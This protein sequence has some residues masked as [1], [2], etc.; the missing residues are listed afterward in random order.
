[1]GPLAPFFPYRNNH[2]MIRLTKV[3]AFFLLLAQLA[4]FSSISAQESSPAGGKNEPR[5][6]FPETTF[7]FGRVKSST[8][9]SHQFTVTNTGKARLEISDVRP[10]CGCT[11]PGKW[12]RQIEPGQSGKIPIQFNPSGFNGSVTKTITV[13]SN[14][15]TQPLRTLTIEAT[16]WQ[17]IEIQPA[18]LY[19]TPTE[20]EAADQT[21]VVRI[22]SNL[23]HALSFGTPQSSGAEFKF[24]LKTVEPGKRFELHVT[25]EGNAS[26]QR[27][28]TFTTS[29]ADFPVISL[30]VTVM[31]QPA[32]ALLPSH[33]TLPAGHLSSGYVHEQIILNRS[34]RAF[35]LT[36]ASVNADN[37]TVTIGET[38]PGKMF[39]LS[40][41][42][43]PNFQAPPTRV[44]QLSIK[45]SDPKYPVIAIPIEIAATTSSGAPD[46]RTIDR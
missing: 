39:A 31:P 25:N 44:L 8:V 19:F 46:V 2:S 10:G 3:S 29:S 7:N 35:N 11:L 14:D 34:S 30:P 9:L 43:P 40:V 4:P 24:Q 33:I 15:P 20:G 45:T 32:I 5:I 1:M 23:E 22:T 36:E 42:F 37:V 16:I 12:D 13:A 17:P 41:S 21:H 6:T 27:L 28:I 18:H 38:R 26:V